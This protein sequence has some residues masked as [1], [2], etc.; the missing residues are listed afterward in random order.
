MG[1]N[2]QRWLFWLSL[3][4][5]VALVTYKV[6]LNF[7]E[8]DFAA[9]HAVQV[10]RIEAALAGRDTY[11]FAVLGNISNSVGVFERKIIPQLNREGYDFVV[12]A[13]N[14]VSSG[15]EDKY[16][17]IYRTLA[18][19]RMPYLLTFGP[20]E[21]SRLGG[22][23]FYD[24]FGPLHF[25]FSAGNSRLLFLD[26]TGTTDFGWQLRWLEEELAAAREPNLLLFS[27]HPLY[28]VDRA[29]LF[30]LNDQYL[31]AEAERARF[32]SL[33]EQAGVDAVFSANLPRFTLQ[34]QADTQYVVTGGAGGLVINNEQSHYH[35]VAVSVREDQIVIEERQL[36]I[37]QHPFWRILESLWFFIHSLFYVGY[38]NFLLLVSVFVAAAI[39][40]RSRVFTERDYYPDF[41][42]D[43]DALTDLPMRVAMFTN[44]YLPFIGGVPLSIERLRAGLARHG[45]TTLI[46]AP[47]YQNQRSDGEPVVRVPT[48]F[49]F[50][51]R[52][53]FPLANIFSPLMYRQARRFQPDIIH[54]HHPVW[55]GSAGLWLGRRLG[56]P[57][58]YTYHTRLEHYAHYVPLPGPLF[59][60]LVS[61]AIIRRFAN[62][63]DGVIVPAESAQEYLRAI[64]VRRRILVQPTGVDI[65]AFRAVPAPSILQLRAR[66]APQGE[67][68]LITI[69]RLS[70]EKNLDFLIDSIQQLR[71]ICEQSFRLLIIGDGPERDRIEAR[72]KAEGLAGTVMLLGAVAPAQIPAYC[73]MGDLFLFASRSETQGMVILEAMAA[74][75]PVVA[76][77]SSG[78][79]D[80]VENGFNGFKTPLDSTRW[81]SAIAQLIGDPVLL[82]RLSENAMSCAA[83]Y[84]VSRFSGDVR[85]F[86]ASLIAARHR[87]RRYQAEDSATDSAKIAS[88]QLD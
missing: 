27:A 14:A 84:S 3:S 51:R 48:L 31:F 18:R 8:R 60:N 34:T 52:S 10:E 44:N 64:G 66:Y 2:T 79:D 63:C 85:S 21:L 28:P 47:H 13:G 50:G 70:A 53:E 71:A 54:V 88:P 5:A 41:D 9:E 19:L 40:L 4:S 16:R 29:G 59:R 61:H 22:F 32:S 37:G 11:R 69:S 62:R 17:A 76:V 24:H 78:I 38:L 80:I 75:M 12:S 74:G 55:M 1:R 57:V 6:Y 35:F 73:R 68:L 86:Y 23:R 36:Q 15:G 81:C 39:W 7:F 58:V 46:V 56:I 87:T 72:I 82:K 25:S 42:T 30:G 26:S 83:N 67:R 45:D 43:P 20:Q 77:R 65:D 49:P 33:I